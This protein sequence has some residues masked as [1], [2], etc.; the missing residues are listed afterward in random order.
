VR[1]HIVK[2]KVTSWDG[3]LFVAPPSELC[4]QL[5]RADIASGPKFDW[6]ISNPLETNPI[7]YSMLLTCGCYMG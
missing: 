6:Y 4:I 1:S 5:R 2:R 3:V 7:S